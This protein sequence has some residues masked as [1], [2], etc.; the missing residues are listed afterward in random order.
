[1][2]SISRLSAKK[3]GA[4]QKMRRFTW[5]LSHF[6]LDFAATMANIVVEFTILP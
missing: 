6:Q 5:C 4:E 1:M 2:A 3:V